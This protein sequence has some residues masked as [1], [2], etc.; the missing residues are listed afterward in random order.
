MRE[1][2]N[3][4]PEN[5]WVFAGVALMGYIAY[6]PF[7]KKRACPAAG[8]DPRR[9]CAR[10]RPHTRPAAE[11]KVGDDPFSHEAPTK[12]VGERERRNAGRFQRDD[13]EAGE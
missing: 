12:I 8:N 13:K 7:M 10:S 9:R 1:A 11:E 6:R 5:V 2:L 4:V 3:K